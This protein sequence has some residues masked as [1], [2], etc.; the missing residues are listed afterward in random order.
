ML[1]KII[2]LTDFIWR[3]VCQTTYF[4]DNPKIIKFTKL[5][6]G[7]QFLKITNKIKVCE[8]CKYTDKFHVKQLA[9]FLQN[10]TRG[11]T[12]QIKHGLI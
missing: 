5:G 11:F 3:K 9:H 4:A 2:F 6:T 7:M 10:T 8:S 1:I 12:V